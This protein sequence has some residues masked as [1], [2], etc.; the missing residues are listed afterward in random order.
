MAKLRRYKF[1]LSNL[2]SYG[3]GVSGTTTEYNILNSF[4]FSSGTTVCNYPPLLSED[5]A[6]LNK[7]DYEK[8]IR[9]F[10]Y[11]K[12]VEDPN[13]ISKLI[14]ESETIAPNIPTCKLND[15][16]L[17]YQF[18]DGVRVVNV[19]KGVGQIEYKAYISTD[20][21]DNYSW[22]TSA[23]FLGLNENETYVFQVRDILNGEVYCMVERTVS[24]PLLVPSTVPPPEEKIVSLSI[25][26]DVEYQGGCYQSG[27][28]V[29]NPNLVNS[30]LISLNYLI[31]ANGI[32]GGTSCVNVF[33]KPNGSNTTTIIRN[34]TESSISPICGNVIINQGD[35]ITYELISESMSL[36]TESS[37][38]LE[39]TS[40]NGL[41]TTLPIIDA[42][43]CCVSISTNEP[44]IETIVNLTGETNYSL[45]DTC[46]KCGNIYIDP[47]IPTNYSIDID[48][49]TNVVRSLGGSGY[50]RIRCKPAGSSI[51]SDVL[52]N[53]QLDPQPQNVI[54]NLKKDDDILFCIE[55]KHSSTPNS[56]GCACIELIGA[57]GVTGIDATIS[58]TNVSQSVFNENVPK[59][60]TVSICQQNCTLLSP[61]TLSSDGFINVSPALSGA[62]VVDVD[63]DMISTIS[64]SAAFAR[65]VIYCKPFG[66]SNYVIISGLEH[67]NDSPNTV[68]SG[69]VKIRSGDQICY[70]LQ[71]E[72]FSD[73]VTGTSS[74][75]ITNV[76][77][78]NG[79]IPSISSTK[80]KDSI[81]AD[82]IGIPTTVLLGL[83]GETQSGLFATLREGGL[84]INP[85]IPTIPN[86]NYIDITLN[87][88]VRTCLGASGCVRIRCI[89]SGSVT[90][91]DVICNTGIYSQN[92]T[93]RMRKGDELKYFLNATCDNATI[94]S[95]AYSCIRISNSQGSPAIT[96]TID[97]TKN[98]DSALAQKL[99]RPITVSLNVLD[100]L[101]S[102]TIDCSCGLVSLSSDLI[103]TD[104]ITVNYT[105]SVSECVAS[106]STVFLFCKEYGSTTYTPFME[107]CSSTGSICNG[108][109]NL[110]IGECVCYE[111]VAQQFGVV[112]SCSEASFKINSLSSTSGIIT[113]L[114]TSCDVVN[115]ECS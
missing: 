24:L 42:S 109:F 108:S 29:I 16:F 96:P 58:T 12:N 101:T 32:D 65:T 49:R 72:S 57:T 8:R 91:T 30:E 61:C 55:G 105:A 17:V 106:I 83:T 14:E 50:A 6:I 43:M 37:A 77:G 22:Q 94:G 74:I 62:E 110:N 53:T 80:F 85:T 2:I 71:A 54:I 1:N 10:L 82:R 113:T 100:E 25:G 41:G 39:L 60:V 35:L 114:G 86:T 69:I 97:T 95:C 70:S 34:V 48:V 84:T 63:V 44:A 7:L 38:S 20:D 104:R 115:V 87:T 68:N 33:C 52:Y 73:W 47:D 46:A 3:V 4:T 103:F 51:Y 90:G 66:G 92:T 98:S 45:G 89:P 9:D 5:I 28:V 26:T 67:S 107:L 36:G 15:S 21:P 13:V 78:F 56:C 59:P 40:T 64:D 31:S 79:I 18:F 23:T 19:G 76:T 112:G 11:T 102:P 75:Q 81:I 93:V 99:A 27:S 88:S 111:I